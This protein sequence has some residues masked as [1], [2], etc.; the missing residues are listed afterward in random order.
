MPSLLLLVLVLACTTCG[1]NVMVTTVSAVPTADRQQA[2]K[3]VSFLEDAAS[4]SD[5]PR[6]NR[7][8]LPRSLGPA[9]T[10]NIFANQQEADGVKVQTSPH[11]HLLSSTAATVST[12]PSPKPATN[13]CF[14]AQDDCQG[15]E[16]VL[17]S[18]GCESS[19]SGPVMA[20]K[21]DVSSPST[22]TL[23]VNSPGIGDITFHIKFKL[24][25]NTSHPNSTLPPSPPQASWGLFT[26]T[27]YYNQVVIWDGDSVFGHSDCVDATLPSRRTL[28]YNDDSF[29]VTFTRAELKRIGLKMCALTTFAFAATVETYMDIQGP[30]DSGPNWQLYIQSIAWDNLDYNCWSG[31][32]VPYASFS[33][34]YCPCASPPLPPSPPTP[35]S[36]PPPPPPPP[37]FCGPSLINFIRDDAYLPSITGDVLFDETS[38]LMA[39]KFRL[40]EYKVIRSASRLTTTPGTP[41]GEDASISMQVFL[42]LPAGTEVYWELYDMQTYRDWFWFTDRWTWCLGP[43]YSYTDYM[44]S[45][46]LDEPATNISISFTL[47]DLQVVGIRT[48]TNSTFMLLVRI[49][50]PTGGDYY[51]G[52][53]TDGC[54]LDSADDR[55]WPL[56]RLGVWYCPCPSPPPQPPPAL[57]PPPVPSPPPP[58]FPPAFPTP[59]PPY[60]ATPSPSP[61][62]PTKDPRIP[63]ILKQPNRPKRPTKPTRSAHP[64]RAH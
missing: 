32:W 44:K 34:R 52:W 19:A 1:I 47:I 55:V 43:P 57:S 37:L 31:Q 16:Q 4:L 42:D 22:A 63:R 3:G 45:Q 11:R 18:S 61:P 40:S 20:S 35:P 12:P 46:V 59:P 9:G 7:Q 29:N 64:L 26:E 24:R 30:N 38:S 27:D 14:A 50:P 62:K 53:D 15:R 10:A 56:V 2:A 6:T 25:Y 17:L 36:P 21:D 60:P 48:C 13:G 39:H 28:G 54:N 5:D 23:F 8:S 33:L 51:V 41:D 58:L 49:R